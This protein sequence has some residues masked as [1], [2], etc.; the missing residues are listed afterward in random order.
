MNSDVI[1]S[2]LQEILNEQ[3]EAVKLIKQ[4]IS[5]IENLQKE[6]NSSQK[7]ASIGDTKAFEN[8]TEALKI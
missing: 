4:L 1:E 2:V 8:I 7:I 5:K 3:K 6:T